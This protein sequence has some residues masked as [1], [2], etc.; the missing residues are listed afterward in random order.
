MEW[1][2]ICAIDKVNNLQ[3]LLKDSSIETILEVGCGTGAV[4]AEVERRGIGGKHVGVDMADPSA[5]TDPHAHDLTL[6]QYDGKS[7]PF[8]DASFDFVYASHVIEHV[9]DPRGLISEMS[10]V[11]KKVIYIEV[12][13]ELHFRS[14]HKSLQKTVDIGHINPYNLESFLLLLQTSGLDVQE[15]KVFDHSLAAQQFHTSLINGSLKKTLRGTILRFNQI[16][17]SRLFTY[18]CGAL[19]CPRSSV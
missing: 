17:A 16:L 9:P 14:N 7:L 13:L 3:A 5:H 10:R 4:L 6:I 11:A 18:H 1:R 15:I 12:P 19:C 2:R 8:S